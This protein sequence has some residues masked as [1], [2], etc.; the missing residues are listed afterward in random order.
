MSQE[1]AQAAASRRRTG[2]IVAFIA[3]I[4]WIVS[5]GGVVSAIALQG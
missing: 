4:W 5:I 2:T 1:D 3:V